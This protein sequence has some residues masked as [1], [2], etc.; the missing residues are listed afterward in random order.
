MIQND[1]GIPGNFPV[2]HICWIFCTQ[3]LFI[4]RHMLGVT[5]KICTTETRNFLWKL[6]IAQGKYYY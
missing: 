5:W 6:E 3:M 1:V 4:Y 2:R